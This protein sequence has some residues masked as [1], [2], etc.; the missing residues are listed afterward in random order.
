M[1]MPNQTGC[2]FENTLR[3]GPPRNPSMENW[4]SGCTRI[5]ATGRAI[6]GLKARRHF[7]FMHPDKRRIGRGLPTK[8]A[9]PDSGRKY[10]G[11]RSTQT[12]KSSNAKRQG[13]VIGFP[14]V[15][16]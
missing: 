4:L 14:P 3:S 15:R 13:R 6:H 1:F 8:L 9:R 10:F 2:D 16:P 12:L 5:Y 11:K 7:I